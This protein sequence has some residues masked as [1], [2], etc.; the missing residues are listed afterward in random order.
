MPEQSEI[1]DLNGDHIQPGEWYY[2]LCDSRAFQNLGNSVYDGL[3]RVFVKSVQ[4]LKEETGWEHFA[5]VE[6]DKGV[7]YAMP[8]TRLRDLI[9]I[10]SEVSEEEIFRR[11]LT[12]GLE[13]QAKTS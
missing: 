9:P 10:L 2:D 13:K 12:R 8:Q 11:G 4:R 7:K 5:I 1:V 3:G 6:D